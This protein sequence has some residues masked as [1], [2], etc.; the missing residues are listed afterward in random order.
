MPSIVAES[1]FIYSHFCICWYPCT[2]KNVQNRGC[3]SPTENFRKILPFLGVEEIP[4]I[5]SIV[6]HLLSIL[7]L[8]SFHWQL[9]VSIGTYREQK[10]LTIPPR[11]MSSDNPEFWFLYDLFSTYRKFSA[12]LG[13]QQQLTFDPFP[14]ASTNSTMR[15]L[16]GR[17]VP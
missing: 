5:K 17:N 4:I 13:S 2:S 16:T 10:L 9:I 11:K 6:P 1:V 8:T 15:H 14:P 3:F 12:G 7:H